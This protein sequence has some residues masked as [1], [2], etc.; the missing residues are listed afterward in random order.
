MKK[1][2]KFE[3]EIEFEE[4]DY[5]PTK[6]KIL[7]CNT[8]GDYKALTMAFVAAFFLHKDK[9]KTKL[10]N[11]KRMVRV[12]RAIASAIL[13]GV[14]NFNR[15]K[16]DADFEKTLGQSLQGIIT[17]CTMGLSENMD[18]TKDEAYSVEDDLISLSGGAER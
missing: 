15:D 13:T 4:G 2:A 7:K 6:M 14:M 1:T 18:I 3:I 5:D 17:M 12:Q 8:D 9:T 10:E 11:F 16:I